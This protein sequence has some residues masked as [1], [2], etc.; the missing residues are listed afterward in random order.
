MEK[1]H[2]GTNTTCLVHPPINRHTHISNKYVQQQNSI[3]MGSI[4]IYKQ[5]ECKTEQVQDCKFSNE[6]ES[7]DIE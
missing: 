3:A 7:F 2:F 4:C 1:Q 5:Q 6:F